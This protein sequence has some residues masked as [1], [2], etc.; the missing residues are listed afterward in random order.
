VYEDNGD[1]ITDREEGCLIYGIHTNLDFAKWCRE[2]LDMN[3]FGCFISETLISFVHPE[4]FCL[5]YPH[6][7][8][9]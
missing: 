7:P 9:E 6:T 4:V 8:T 5:W 3:K 2:H 1:G